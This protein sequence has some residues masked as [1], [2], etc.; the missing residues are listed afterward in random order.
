MSQRTAF[1]NVISK[2]CG[3]DVSHSRGLEEEDGYL[4]DALREWEPLT[5][6]SLKEGA[7]IPL[8]S[9]LLRLVP[10][11]MAT[12]IPFCS[13][14]LTLALSTED[15]TVVT[16]AFLRRVVLTYAE[17]YHQSFCIMIDKFIQPNRPER[18]YALILLS[19]SL[20]L[21]QKVLPSIVNTSLWASLMNNVKVETSFKHFIAAVRVVVIII[22][23][24]SHALDPYLKDLLAT[25]IS[26]LG[27]G[28]RFI[29]KN[30]I[31]ADG[32]GS[33]A[34]AVGGVAR[35]GATNTSAAAMG[36]PPTMPPT[37]GPGSG[38][39]NIAPSMTRHGGSDD[40][41]S[42]DSSNSS[43]STSTNDSFVGGEAIETNLEEYVIARSE[44]YGFS[45][46]S[47]DH[48]DSTSSLTLC[49]ETSMRYIEIWS[50]KDSEDAVDS[51]VCGFRVVVTTRPSEGAKTS[52][53]E[54]P[55]VGRM[56]SNRE[57]I[58]LEK[59]EYITGMLFWH[60]L[61]EA[62]NR[63]YIMGIALTS[64]IKQFD[65]VGSPP[66]PLSNCDAFH[67]LQ[68]LD[69]VPASL[70]RNT[71]HP[72]YGDEMLGVH[73]T[74][75]RGKFTS[76]GATFIHIN[77]LERI[78]LV[79]RLTYSLDSQVFESMRERENAMMVGQQLFVLL[80]AL[81]P[82][83]VMNSLRNSMKENP[84]VKYAVGPLLASVRAVPSMLESHNLEL[85]KKGRVSGADR[86]SDL[87]DSIMCS[88]S[89]P[90]GV[91]GVTNNMTMPELSNVI[92]EE[93][94]AKDLK[95]VLD[96]H[97]SL[98]RYI[99][100]PLWTSQFLAKSPKSTPLSETIIQASRSTLLA[101]SSLLLEKYMRS[102]A[103]V[104]LRRLNAK[105]RSVS[106][107]EAEIVALQAIL[108]KE[109]EA[110]RVLRDSLDATRYDF[111]IKLDDQVKAR[112]VE[113][114]RFNSLDMERQKYSKSNVYLSERNKYLE[115]EM[116]KF[117][118]ELEEVNRANLDLHSKMKFNRD[119]LERA[120]KAEQQVDTLNR[121]LA[122]WHKRDRCHVEGAINAVMSNHDEALRALTCELADTQERLRV[123]LEYK[124]IVE[125]NMEVRSSLQL[126]KKKDE[127]SLL[128]TE[129]AALRN[130]VNS[131][132]AIHQ[133]Q[134][135]AAESKYEGIKQICLALEKQ[136]VASTFK[137]E[138]A[139]ER[140]MK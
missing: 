137:S 133:D 119:Y 42:E 64:N 123:A 27:V 121:E 31:T 106:S 40:S 71:Y 125:R 86:V 127:T 116:V 30:S 65:W 6:A 8:Q 79:D 62:D 108:E 131:Q 35:G 23:S 91:K 110:F 85:E 51:F 66:S 4:T 80:Y 94:Y 5:I 82:S 37:A 56:S 36:L 41:S 44:R 89:S 59:G 69:A 13:H 109:R 58:C 114:N 60:Q 45:A 124:E 72:R 102:Q 113:R 98:L 47:D 39:T 81:Y 95:M 50:D 33:P 54:V 111:T 136:I 130:L 61:D 78:V 83:N 115:E 87:V 112:N 49:K 25:F 55:V 101:E 10:W 3:I 17:L 67:H 22:P 32:R 107:Q 29:H 76:L 46:P 63:E 88:C 96:L 132:H 7:F 126:K 77:S 15:T 19:Q 57:I 128:Q 129:V 134:L 138:G 14:V 21:N 11:W 73:G 104:K 118:N 84:A 140:S 52:T 28:P 103:E 43:G 97:E 1:F 135:A 75:F 34:S 53:E 105:L 68:S 99:S 12:D 26:I 120:V 117:R 24:I 9:V 139:K 20:L 92:S 90:C 100:D 16:S 74:I 122:L 70:G 18:G 93:K 2:I 38:G 48:F